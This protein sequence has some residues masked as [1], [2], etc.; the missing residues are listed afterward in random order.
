MPGTVNW[1]GRA[2][3]KVSAH[4]LPQYTAELQAVFPAATF[5]TVYDCFKGFSSDQ[6][7]KIVLGVEVRSPEAYR[8][9]IVKLGAREVVANDYDGWRKCVF[10]HN[11][12]SRI[13]VSLEKRELPGAPGRIAIIYQDAYTLFGP[14][15]QT[16]SPQSLETITTWAIHDGKP[17]PMSV[18]RVIRQIYGD[19]SRWFYGNARDDSQAVRHFYARR[20][21]RARDKWHDEDWRQTLRRDV[22]WLLCGQEASDLDTEAPYLDPYDYVCW[23]LQQA[24]VPQTLVGRSHGD[25]HGRNVLVGVQRGE[26]EYPAVFDYGD[27]DYANVLVWD[28]VKLETELKVRLLLPLYEDAAARQ[29]VLSLDTDTRQPHG[30]ASEHRSF[31]PV[32][33]HALRLEQ[34]RFACQFE[35]LL[36]KLTR[37]IYTLID[38]EALSPLDGRVCSGHPKIDRALAILLRIRREA[39]VCLGDRQPQRGQ[40]GLWHDEYH[41]ALAVYGL[42][43]AKFDYKAFETHFALISAGVA[44]AQIEMAR[45]EIRAQITA[46]RVPPLPRGAQAQPPYPSYRVP[47]VHA[48]R[49]W[50][51]GRSQTQ[52]TQALRF[53]RHAVPSFGHA[54]PLLQEYALVLTEAGHLA[55]ARDVLESSRQLCGVFRDYE[56]L[57]RLGRTW[58]DAGDLAW[59]QDPVPM[60]QLRG[61][62]A[63][64]WYR[65]AYTLYKEAFELSTHYYPGVNAATLAL[66]IGLKEQA[67]TLAEAVLAICEAH[68]AE[69]PAE[70]QFWVLAS[71]GEAALVL[72]D[73]DRAITFYRAALRVLHLDQ[74]GMAQSAYN[75]VCRLWWALGADMVGPV[76]TAFTQ[77]A[78]WSRLQPGP[79]ANCGT[80]RARGRPS[81]A[82]PQE[83]GRRRRRKSPAGPSTE[84]LQ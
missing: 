32:D 35:T 58:K 24:R 60:A 5:V 71:E 44:A 29:V 37:G 14:D 61:R 47:L 22:I 40:R 46:K 52:I 64:Q 36:A 11:F 45:D 27:M 4:L 15:A 30:T 26:A 50:Q 65:T 6:A 12:A 68:G 31:A 59:A 2:S 72:G 17:D 78:L 13:F 7:R 23:A 66:L 57:A 38:P 41:F 82:P 77:C 8:T 9:H 20:L 83:Q 81:T 1:M 49:L 51:L 34:L 79:F 63:W 67:H 25:L 62:P 39:A 55:Q 43:T 54:V 33:P 74:A 3:E 76:A 19:L 73:T 21:R 80:Q 28:F 56:T 75:Q 53:L 69:L 10:A 70:E 42:C 18:E 48:H 16:Q 84:V